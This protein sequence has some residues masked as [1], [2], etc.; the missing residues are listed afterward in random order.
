MELA[1]PTVRSNKPLQLTDPACHAPCFGTGRA[2]P[3]RS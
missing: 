1:G 2:N 3:T